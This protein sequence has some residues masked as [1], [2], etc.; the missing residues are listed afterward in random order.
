MT[1]RIALGIDRYL[2]EGGVQHCVG[3]LDA[4]SG[5]GEEVSCANAAPFNPSLLCPESFSQCLCFGRRLLCSKTLSFELLPP[6]SVIFFPSFT[7]PDIRRLIVTLLPFPPFLSNIENLPV[8]KCME[9]SIMNPSVP[10][11]QL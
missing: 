6:P 3:G 1:S 2:P 11:L 7:C 4:G 9:T 5:S 10:I 8:C